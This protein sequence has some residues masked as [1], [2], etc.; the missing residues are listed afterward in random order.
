[1][2]KRYDAA[3]AW[4]LTSTALL[5]EEQPAVVVL[6]EEA[7]T[8]TTMIEPPSPTLSPPP[9]GGAASSD[10]DYEAAVIAN[11]HVQAAGVQNI[12]SLISDTLDLS[13]THYVRWRDNVLLTLG[14]YSLSN[15]V[16]MDTTYVGVLSSDRMDNVVKSWIYGIISPDLQDVTRQHGHTARDA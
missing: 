5:E 4:V 13:S 12:C 11:V 9:A 6:T 15:H 7:P 3:H 16:L 2:K 10:D 8:A 14:R 1:V